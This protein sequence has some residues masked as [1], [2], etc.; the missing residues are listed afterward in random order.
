MLKKMLSCAAFLLLACVVCAAPVKV[1]EK[2]AVV[3]ESAAVK[4]GEIV[5]LK[6]VFECV[7]G[8][9]IGSFKAFVHR[10]EAP[11]E[12]FARNSDLIRWRDR[13]NKKVSGYDAIWITNG[14]NFPVQLA[15]GECEIVI[16]TSGMAAGDYS[17]PVQG[18]V[19]K[20][21]KSYYCASRFYLTITGEDGKKFVATPQV[22]PAAARQVKAVKNPAWIKN[23]VF[24]PAEPAGVAGSKHQ[25]NCDLTV[26]DKYFFG[27][28]CVKVLRKDAPEAFFKREN[29]DM[30][31]RFK[32]KKVDGY[33]YAIL[34][35]FKHMP[36][37][38]SQKF[39]FELDTASFPAGNYKIAVEVRLVD[40]VTGKTSYPSVFLPMIVQ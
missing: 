28:Y 14:K 24:T 27:G 32:D 31:Y 13:K 21:K 18:W 16:N 30:R 33:D 36:S 26:S 5:K 19:L 15:A 34:V 9:K 7:P 1:V 17:I 23:C 2:F 6:L 40:R 3:P 20:D 11:A 10:K 8:A 22:L 4:A 35:K 12:F 39:G 25:V 37:V 29:L 38:E